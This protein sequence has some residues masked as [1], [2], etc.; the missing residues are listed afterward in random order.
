MSLTLEQLASIAQI[1]SAVAVPIAVVAL[2]APIR[3][4][5]KLTR[6]ANAQKLAE[7]AASL[8]LQ[9]VQY[10][11]IA[12][13]WTNGPNDFQTYSS[14]DKFRFI[15][16]LTWFLLLHE[17]VFLQRS[18]GLLDTGTFGAWQSDLGTL[19]SHSHLE[20]HWPSLRKMFHPKFAHHVD[21]LLPRGAS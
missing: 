4:Q 6:V 2:I 9:F 19:I 17:T 10:E 7:L 13:Y 18:E 14:V 20:I 1:F 8:N 15:S 16:L 3:Y 11:K 5:I 12:D 21:S